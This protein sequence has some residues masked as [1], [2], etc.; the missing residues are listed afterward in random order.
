MFSFSHEEINLSLAL[1][2]ILAVA[3][4]I[5]TTRILVAMSAQM[6]HEVLVMHQRG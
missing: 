2:I 1:S 5:Q 6:F 4:I 3:R